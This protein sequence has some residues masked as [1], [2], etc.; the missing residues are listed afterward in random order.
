MSRS[1]PVSP[2]HGLMMPPPFAP[3]RSAEE[4]KSPQP[5]E[6]ID[7][8]MPG[9]PKA[10]PSKEK[11]A[12]MDVHSSNFPTVSVASGQQVQAPI[13]VPSEKSIDSSQKVIIS[14]PTDSKDL[15]WTQKT[16]LVPAP[17]QQQTAVSVI[18]PQPATS[19][20]VFQNGSVK[21]EGIKQYNTSEQAVRSLDAEEVLKARNQQQFFSNIQSSY[22]GK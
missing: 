7:R 5:M 6:N 12:N 14:Q 15:L 2:T 19:N 13:S 10:S 21:I 4:S 20:S 17:Q 22:S 16:V 18:R 3:A 11:L 1:A 9:A 8:Q